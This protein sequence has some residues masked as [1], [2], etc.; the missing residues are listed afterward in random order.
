[1]CQPLCIVMLESY[2]TPGPQELKKL[3]PATQ[4]PGIPTIAVPSGRGA[5]QAQGT[6]FMR[7]SGFELGVVRVWS[8]K[9][10]GASVLGSPPCS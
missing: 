3:T 6:F 4:G 1:M 7:R 10:H 9:F 5:Q 2:Q 8:M